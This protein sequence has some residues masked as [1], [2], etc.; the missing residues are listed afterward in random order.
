MNPKNL[1]Q[2]P[3]AKT[4]LITV[5]WEDIE[6]GNIFYWQGRRW[7]KIGFNEGQDLTTGRK[8]HP[9]L[10]AKFKKRVPIDA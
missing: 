2:K 5:G 4:K 3:K 10:N 9:I 8:S 1:H 7:K 6:P